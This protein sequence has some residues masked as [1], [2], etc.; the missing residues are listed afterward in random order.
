M[1]LLDSQD[2]EAENGDEVEGVPGHAVECEE[3]GELS[4][5]DVGGREHGVEDERIDGRVEQP[6]LL[7]A[8]EPPQASGEAAPGPLGG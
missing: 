2:D 3:G 8:E 7:V 6:C 5:E 1:G 4:D